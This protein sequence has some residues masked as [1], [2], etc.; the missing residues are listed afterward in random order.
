MAAAM[1][2]LCTLINHH[3]SYAPKVE[4]VKCGNKTLVIPKG[5]PWLG[6]LIGK[7]TKA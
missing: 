3:I 4:L 5:T 1:R 7:F 2:S 6:S